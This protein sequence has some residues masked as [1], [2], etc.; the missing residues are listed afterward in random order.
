VTH[1]ERVHRE[2]ARGLVLTAVDGV[3]GA[4]IDDDVG[5][6]GREERVDGGRIGDLELV[7]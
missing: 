3:E 4:G 2:R 5:S 7:V 6:H 1:R